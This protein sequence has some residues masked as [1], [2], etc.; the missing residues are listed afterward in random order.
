MPAAEFRERRNRTLASS[1]VVFPPEVRD[2]LLA[3]HVAQR[4]LQLHQLDEQ[5][6]LRVQPG[7]VLG[8]LK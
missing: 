7:R 5:V 1:V 6:V 3:Q 8:L 4:V 2:E